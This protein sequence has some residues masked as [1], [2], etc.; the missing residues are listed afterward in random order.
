MSHFAHAPL[1]TSVIDWQFEQGSPSYPFCLAIRMRSLSV[2]DGTP[3]MRF[4]GCGACAC[5]AGRFSGIGLKCADRGGASD[6]A[7]GSSA[8]ITRSLTTS[9]DSNG[10][11]PSSSSCTA[12]P[13]KSSGITCARSWRFKYVI[14]NSRKM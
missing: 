11:S 14:A 6:S 1:R 12:S 10:T 13:R 4:V 5:T 2:P 7:S 3:A 9:S 8:S